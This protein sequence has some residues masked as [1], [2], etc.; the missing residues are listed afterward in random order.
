[1]WPRQKQASTDDN[2][3]GRNLIQK[4][5]NN[6]DNDGG[7]YLIGNNDDIVEVI[8]LCSSD[9]SEDDNDNQYDWIE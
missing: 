5:A 8:D 4:R 3:G 6:D 7:R 9:D 1:M 2:D